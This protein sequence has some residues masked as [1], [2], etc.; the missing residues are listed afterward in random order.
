[1][2][3]GKKK[4]TSREIGRVPAL[5]GKQGVEMHRKILTVTKL[6]KKITVV[7]IKVLYLK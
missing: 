4:I 1:M 3:P 2:L 7:L 6:V 5:L